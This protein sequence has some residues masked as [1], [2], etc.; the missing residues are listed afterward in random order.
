MTQQFGA[1]VVDLSGTTL[2]DEERDILDHPAVGGIILF[3]RNYTS[4][5]QLIQLIQ[6]IRAAR[7]QGIIIMVDQEGGR[8]QRFISEFT[9]LPS[10][11]MIGQ[12]FEQNPEQTMQTAAET[13]YTM[14][15]ELL[16]CDIDLS[17][18]PVVDLNN[19]ISQVIGDRAFHADP[20]V[21]TQLAKAYIRGMNRAGMAATTK[22]FPGHGSIA[23]DSHQ[24]VSTDLRS[25][26]EIAALDLIPFAELSQAV[27]A[28][29]VA[30]I[31]VPV[32]DELP[33]SFSS[34]WLRNI[35]RQQLQFKGCILSDDLNM[36]GANIYTNYADRVRASLEAGC[37]FALLCNNRAGVLQTLAQLS[38]KELQ[39][40]PE[41]WHQLIPKK[42][43]SLSAFLSTNM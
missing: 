28:I 11:G 41:K 15:T 9:R 34:H 24:V 40:S 26:A 22:H 8:V 16:S 32:V 2:S 36:A 7:K 23:H 17:L 42:N 25:F 37:D 35:L 19:P 43:I 14:A 12:S 18:A 10:L 6:S 38:Q 33:V 21:V 31:V 3:S 4:K 13:G 20:Q 39:V 5:K 30:H 29:M 27:A 1:L